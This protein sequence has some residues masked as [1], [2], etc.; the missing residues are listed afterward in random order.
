MGWGLA[1][2]M[3]RETLGCRTLMLAALAAL[4]GGLIVALVGVMLVRAAL[5]GTTLSAQ[6]QWG[7]VTL[8]AV[9]YAAAGAVVGAQL[10]IVAALVRAVT[11]ASKSL[12]PAIDAAVAKALAQMPASEK[13]IA[14]G[15]VED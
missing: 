15:D 4:L 7:I 11:I 13:G 1:K 14:I 12:E 8:A 9:I 6:Q 2:S 10:V 3:A 5:A